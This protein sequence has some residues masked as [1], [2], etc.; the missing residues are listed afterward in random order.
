MHDW[1]KYSEKPKEF[2]QIGML[3]ITNRH[4][5]NSFQNGNKDF[6]LKFKFSK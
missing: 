6:Y 1:K 3:N 4:L 2:P 5:I